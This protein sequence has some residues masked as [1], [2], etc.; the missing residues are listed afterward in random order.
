MERR[1]E[2][3]L[4]ASGHAVLTVLEAEGGAADQSITAEV[5]DISGKG[6]SAV[7][8]RA[9]PAG[10]L[11]RIDFNDQLLLGEV[12]YCEPSERGFRIGVQLEHALNS[13]T[14]LQRLLQGLLLSEG[15]DAG[16]GE[17]AK[18]AKVGRG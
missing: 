8:V 4:I 13:V 15:R 11:V 12:C 6:L 1:Q 7:A 17:P 16:Q 18:K 2:P 10:R 9:I 3:R 5:I 14:Q